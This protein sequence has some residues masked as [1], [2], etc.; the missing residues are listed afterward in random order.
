MCVTLWKL[1]LGQAIQ[2]S[3]NRKLKLELGEFVNLR[4]SRSMKLEILKELEQKLG[5]WS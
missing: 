3:K 2:S 4:N 1:G 5:N